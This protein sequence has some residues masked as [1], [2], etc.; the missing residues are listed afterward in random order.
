MDHLTAER[1]EDHIRAA[2][3]PVEVVKNQGKQAAMKRIEAARRLF[4]G[5]WFNE[6]TTAAGRLA[7]GWYH[8]KKNSLGSGV[9]PEHDDSSHGADAFGLMCIAHET[10]KTIRTIKYETRGI[11]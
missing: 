8:E 9:G 7:L 4:P 1:F 10:P 5:I 11:V 2:G 3:F 6:S